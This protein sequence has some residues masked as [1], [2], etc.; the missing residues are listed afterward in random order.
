MKI[1]FLGGRGIPA[2]YGG[3]D[4]LIEEL[5]VRLAV[6][7]QNEVV[8]YCRGSYY[9]NRD[10]SY[11]GVR[12]V[13]LPAPRLKG[14]ESLFNS[15]LSTIH[16]LTIKPHIIYFVDP[17]NAPFC[18]LLRLFGKIVIM[19]TDG[20]GWK[21]KKWS[22]P[23][24]YYY[25]TAEWLS[26]KCA[27]ALITDNPEME[28]YYKREYNANSTMI[29]Y[30]AFNCHGTDPL[31]FHKMGLR[32]KK[33]CLVVARLGAENNTDLIIREYVGSR[34]TLPLIIV[35]DS[36]YDPGYLSKLKMI[37]D[38][39]VRFFGRIDDQRL[40]NT[41]YQGAYIYIHGHEVGGTNPSLL[42]AMGAGTMPLVMNASCNKAVIKDCGAV[43]SKRDGS[44]SKELED[45]EKTSDLVELIGKAAYARAE[46]EFTWEI[47]TCE[48]KRLFS[49]LVTAEK[50]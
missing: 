43:F 18:L 36:P 49:A 26:A 48:H 23:A 32:R 4:T 31:G 9:E 10:D 5:S 16:A 29:S 25:K 2:R 30:G 22:G 47:V 37:S 40:L 17:A 11:M 20:L 41:L 28:A 24:R 13:Y 8:V 21:R 34:A 39:R 38:S 50:S 3:Y 14:F 27:T 46:S 42:R 6:D 33:Y 44:L 45:L 1:A 15:L 35:G 7:Q 19:H 12:T